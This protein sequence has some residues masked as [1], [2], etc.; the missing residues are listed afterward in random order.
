M[1]NIHIENVRVIRNLNVLL[2]ETK[3][4][5]MERK[6]EIPRSDIFTKYKI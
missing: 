6:Y 3:T 4:R 2:E 5:H 1:L